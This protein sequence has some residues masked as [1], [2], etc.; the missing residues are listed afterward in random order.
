MILSLGDDVVV[1]GAGDH[2]S[3]RALDDLGVFSDHHTLLDG[4]LRAKLIKTALEDPWR[5]FGGWLLRIYLTGRVMIE[6]PLE[7]LES[8]AFPGRQGRLLFVYLAMDPRRVERDELANLLWP[9][10]LPNAWDIS[11]SAIISKLRKVLIRSGLDGATTPQSTY[12][13][14]EIRLP[15]DTWIDL[16][17]AINSL[18][19]AEGSLAHGEPR[20]AWADAIVASTILRRPFLPGESGR[21]VDQKRRELHELEVRTYDTLSGAWLLVGNPSAAQQAARQ[22]VD[23][24]PFR[25]SG[26][27]RLMECHLAAGNRAEAIRVYNEVRDLLQ[28]SMGISPT[29]EVEDLYQRSLG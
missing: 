21:W 8:S 29:P 2:C 12:G 4:F 27:A 13:C 26:Y 28:E 20:S 6:T 10:I 16:R 7:V 15:G 9:D 17:E 5:S 14:Y 25:E 1:A 3:T 11:L 23:L 18:D 24:A 19:R 22:A